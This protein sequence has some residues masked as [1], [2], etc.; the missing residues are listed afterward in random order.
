MTVLKWVKPIC[1]HWKNRKQF[2]IIISFQ[3]ENDF[4]PH[5]QK[6]SR[7]L[8]NFIV[9]Y[10]EICKI[11]KQEGPRFWWH[12]NLVFPGLRDKINKNT[13]ISQYSESTISI[14]WLKSF[15]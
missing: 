11:I 14:V 1:C 4:Y 6:S 7:V 5:R 15:K 13:E 2:F 10:K 3:P 9:W 8:L 12:T